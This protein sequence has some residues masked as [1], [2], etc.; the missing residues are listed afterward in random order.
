[1]C[2]GSS[3]TIEEF[4]SLPSNQEESRD[5]GTKQPGLPDK[6]NRGRELQ[7]KVKQCESKPTTFT[8]CE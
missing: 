4:T 2:H 5:V 6:S 8:L 1:M 3:E 7:D